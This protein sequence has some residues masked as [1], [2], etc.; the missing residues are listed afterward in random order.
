MLGLNL[1]L[2]LSIVQLAVRQL[3]GGDQILQPIFLTKADGTVFVTSD[4]N[5]LVRGYRYVTPQE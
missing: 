2:G 1:A 4:G 5:V 3:I